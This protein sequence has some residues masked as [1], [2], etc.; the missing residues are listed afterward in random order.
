MLVVKRGFTGLV[1]S[2]HLRRVTVATGRAAHDCVR[3]TAR[4][5]H[6]RPTAA[7]ARLVA[8]TREYGSF[9]NQRR[10]VQIVSSQLVPLHQISPMVEGIPSL[11]VTLEFVHE[12]LANGDLNRRVLGVALATTV[13]AKVR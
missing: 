6:R 3:S 10:E 13:A 1:E 7:Q 11:Y 4:D 8:G 2:Q 5:V 12:F 9:E